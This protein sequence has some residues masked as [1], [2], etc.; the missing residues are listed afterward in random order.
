MWV[1]GNIRLLAAVAIAGA[2]FGPAGAAANWYQVFDKTNEICLRETSAQERT[3]AIPQ[4]LL[5]ALSLAETG[6]WNATTQA[7][8]AWPWT[9]TAEGQGR[10]FP[11]KAE[12]IAAVGALQGRGVSNID[13]GCMQINLIH[14]ADAFASLEDAFD[15]AKNVGYGSDFLKRQYQALGTWNDAVGRYH[16]ATPSLAA[17]YRK[18]VAIYWNRARGLPEGT[19]LPGAL[20]APDAV[21]ATPAPDINRM[22]LLSRALRERR[23]AEAQAWRDKFTPAS[24]ESIRRQQL[25]AWRTD[26][27]AERQTDQTAMQRARKALAE[28]R[29][30]IGGGDSTGL[31]FAANRQRQLMQWRQGQALTR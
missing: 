7:S 11:T 10:Y 5:G 28:R 30:L 24:R 15:P 25:A 6:R 8:F 16:S 14:H 29:R 21:A 12:A 26:S 4:G 31:P 20:A 19:P 1:I 3:K 22:A 27:A 18:K 2:A 23:D 13:V 17:A 9:V